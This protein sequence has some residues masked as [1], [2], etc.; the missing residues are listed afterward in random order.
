VNA[1]VLR[2]KSAAAG[3]LEPAGV[4]ESVPDVAEPVVDVESYDAAAEAEIARAAAA[5]ARSEAARLV[6]EAEA[7]AQRIVEAARRRASELEL[8]ARD[9]D[10]EAEAH[11][12]VADRS[13]AIVAT[14]AEL[15]ALEAS[16]DA[17]AEEIGRLDAEATR[18]SVRLEELAAEQAQAQQRHAQA[19]RLDDGAALRAAVLDFQ[20]SAELAQAR[21]GELDRAQARLGVVRGEVEQ[22]CE[23]IGRA[24]VRLV[25]LRRA[26]QGLPDLGDLVG[27]AMNLLPALAMSLMASDPE[28]LSAILL[29]AVPEDRRPVMAEALRLGP[30]NPSAMIRMVSTA[31]GGVI[32]PQ[33]VAAL[34]QLAVQDPEQYEALR[35]I[36]RGE[37]VSEPSPAERAQLDAAGMVAAVLG[38]AR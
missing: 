24:Q 32:G 8:Q 7:E 21:R 3:V 33:V 5:D 31:A 16:R 35:K 18:L 15:V 37:A 22:T 11:Q 2:R 28:R 20:T 1:R 29:A 27:T 36:A 34:Q 12:K 25:V 13:A 17:A 23:A 38:G 26:E 19:L 10:V 4:P 6:A 30:A 9:A 14:E